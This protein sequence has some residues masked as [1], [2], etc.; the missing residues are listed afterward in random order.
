MNERMDKSVEGSQ[1]VGQPDGQPGAEAAA[2]TTATVAQPAKGS[3]EKEEV[4]GGTLL[5][6]AYLVLWVALFVWLWTVRRTQLRLEREVQQLEERLDVHIG[7]TRA[8]GRP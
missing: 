3:P 6:A 8:G 5:I 2:E 4:P 1:A 7:Q